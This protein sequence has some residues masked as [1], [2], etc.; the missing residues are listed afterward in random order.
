[1]KETELKTQFQIIEDNLNE[2]YE[3]NDTE[4]IAKLL[5]DDWTILEPS[6]GLS[7]KEQFLKAIKE[8]RLVHSAMRKEIFEIKL[9]DDIA[10][11][12]TRGKNEGRYLDR[13]FNPEQWITN[14]YKKNNTQWLCIMTQEAPV[15][16][17]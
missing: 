9:Y 1:V 15:S 16:C 14:I 7:N 6:V 17:A 5:S 13:P 10:I 2:A 8:R 4:E 12:I 11:V 3:K